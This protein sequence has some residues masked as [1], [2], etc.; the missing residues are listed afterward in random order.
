MTVSRFKHLEI[1]TELASFYHV[2]VQVFL[3]KLSANLNEY[4]IQKIEYEVI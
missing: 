1:N 4:E 2:I 3:Q